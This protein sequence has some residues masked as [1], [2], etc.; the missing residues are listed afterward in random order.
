M[1]WGTVV[2]STVHWIAANPAGQQQQDAAQMK[3]AL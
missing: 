3:T 1:F 2:D